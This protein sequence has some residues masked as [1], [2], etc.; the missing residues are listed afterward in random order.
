M[1]Q[2]AIILAGPAV[3]ITGGTNRTL[4]QAGPALPTGVHVIDTS[5]VDFRLQPTFDFVSRQPILQKDG[6]YVKSRRSV[7][8]VRPKLLASGKYEPIAG[9]VVIKGH[10]EMT[11]AEL[12]AMKID[13]CQAIMD[14]EFDL[15]WSQGTTA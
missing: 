7:H 10:P 11:A 14:A 6:T 1:I 12:L 4:S 3:A 13:L 5:I 8:I 9:D 15:F 2:N